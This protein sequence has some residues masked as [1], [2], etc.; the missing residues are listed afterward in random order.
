MK[1]S[2]TPILS[3]LQTNRLLNFIDRFAHMRV[4]VIGE[5]ILDRYLQGKTDRICREAPVPIVDIAQEKNVPG[6]AANTAANVATLGAQTFLLSV[7]GG[8]RA[9]EN[10]QAALTERGVQTQGI[11]VDPTRHYT[12]QNIAC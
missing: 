7:V 3:D 1:N 12:S 11:V 9:G 2:A 10:L 6:G 4:L 5:A 8:D